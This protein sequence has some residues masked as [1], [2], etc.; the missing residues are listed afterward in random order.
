[1]SDVAPD[2]WPDDMDKDIIATPVSM[3]K[4]E[5]SYLGPKTK[6]LLK[7]EVRT[8]PQGDG[9]FLHYFMIVAPGL[10]NYQYQ[11]FYAVHT[12]TLYPVTIN[13]N[14]QQYSIPD[15]GRLT[16]MLK[17]ILGSEQTKHILQALIAQVIGPREGQ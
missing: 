9:R 8:A 1:M 17:Q 10:S 4:E 3:L 15:Q 6:Q 2:F 5:A 7:A 14:N 11:L 16:E 12:I 13:W